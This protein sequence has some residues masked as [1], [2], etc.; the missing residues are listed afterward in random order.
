[1]VDFGSES[2]RKALSLSLSMNRLPI[3]HECKGTV[4]HHED[5]WEWRYNFM[6]SEL[7]HLNQSS[8][9]C[10]GCYPTGQYPHLFHSIKGCLGTTLNL[11]AVKNGK[12]L[13]L[14]CELNPDLTKSTCTYPAPGTSSWPHDSFPVDSTMLYTLTLSTLFNMQMFTQHLNNFDIWHG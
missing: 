8:A 11:N 4:I 10:R 7:Q 13:C 1:M 2:V 5:V 9:L 12:K 3:N 14:C 6:H